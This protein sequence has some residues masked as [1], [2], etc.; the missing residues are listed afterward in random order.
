MKH[1]ADLPK[2]NVIGNSVRQLRDRTGIAQYQLVARLELLGLRMD[3]SSLSRIESGKRFVLDY[4]AAALA[5]ALGVTVGEL[6]PEINWREVAARAPE[7]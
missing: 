6:Y 1:T 5:K 2:A 3:Q 7:E 4:E